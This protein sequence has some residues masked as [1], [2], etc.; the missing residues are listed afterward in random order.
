MMEVLL[1]TLRDLSES[2]E[3]G[4]VPA[5]LSK[6]VREDIE[7]HD[8]FRKAELPELHTKLLKLDEV[9]ETGDDGGD[10]PGIDHELFFRGP[11]MCHTARLPSRVRYLGILT[12]TDEVG[13]PAPVGEETYYVGTHREDAEKTPSE[14]S[15]MRIVYET[16]REREKHCTGVVVK[17]DYPDSWFAGWKDDWTSLTIPNAAEREFFG[18]D[19]ERH[20]G[21]IIVHWKKCDWGNCPEGFLTAEDDGDWEMRINSQ[22]VSVID[23]QHGGYIAKGET[24]GFRFEPDPDGRYTIELKIHKKNHY[25]ELA[26]FV[27]Y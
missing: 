12:E 1:E 8:E 25:V 3:A 4:D 24:T 17:P 10:Q 14:D 7:L 5:L 13:G 11:S 22:K 18:Y 19:P 21:V 20:R 2:D 27:L 9:L 26:D 23:I 15:S 16:H 6:L